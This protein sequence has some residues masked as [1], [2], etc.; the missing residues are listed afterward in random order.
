MLSSIK[1]DWRFLVIFSVSLI[2]ISLSGCGR[3]QLFQS[4]S[5]VFGTLV[6]ITI[7]DV[8]EPRARAL[9]NHVMQ[10]FQALHNQLHA[11]QPSELS[12]LNTAFKQGKTVSISPLL[13]Q[14]IADAT[15]LSVNSDG[16]FNP[17]VGG[18]IKA[19]GFQRSEFTPIQP[20]AEEIKALVKANPQ[21]IDIV[22][23]GNKAYSRNPAVQLDLGGYAK[24]YALDIAADY[25]RSQGVKHALI[26]IGGNIIALGQH[27]DSPWRVGIQDP[28]GPSA[29]ATV[30][31]AD[32]WAIGTSGDYQRY[33]ELNGKRYCHIIDP[34]TGY[35]SQGTEAVTVLIPPQKNANAISII[36]KLSISQLSY[37]G[38][39][40]DVLSKPIFLSN[41]TQREVILQKF[42][43]PYQLQNVMIINS[44]HQTFVTPALAKRIQWLRP[45][46]A[47]KAIILGSSA[48]D[49]K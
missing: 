6:D 11:W 5:Y 17:A 32:G 7:V 15:A 35:P 10:E 8:P 43:Q 38:V 42:A 40:S 37:A 13:S 9:A 21:M 14:L 16:L 41:A 3:E 49:V 33:F 26:N 25:L 4:Q 39:L 46:A 24:G 36:G 30:E 47:K 27:G 31:L 12:A 34:R 45:E 20:N 22:L 18:L 44:Q 1:Y 23:N 48:T 29:I 28:R 2:S 19:W